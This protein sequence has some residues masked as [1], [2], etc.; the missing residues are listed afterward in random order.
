MCC[1]V[2]WI[3]YQYI[4]YITSFKPPN[5]SVRFYYPNFTHEEAEAPGNLTDSPHFPGF[6]PRQSYSLDITVH[7][8]SVHRSTKVNLIWTFP[9]RSFSD[10]KE[11][12]IWWTKRSD[13]AHKK[14]LCA[15]STQEFVADRTG[16]AKLRSDISP[17]QF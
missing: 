8:T 6:K 17:K 7:R 14:G 15:F 13:L 10:F 3:L 12:D 9:S 4:T 16:T 2:F 5:C 1:S 11:D